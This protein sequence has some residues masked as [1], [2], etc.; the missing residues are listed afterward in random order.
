MGDLEI[1]ASIERFCEDKD[2][3]F[4]DD[5][6]G[7]SMYGRTCVGIVTDDVFETVI[8]LCD[9]LRDE[10]Y[11]SAKTALGSTV[12]VDNM[13]LSKIAYFPNVSK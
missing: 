3:S 7:R 4:T 9:F 10:G 8:D 5:Y 11:A 13:G 12:N 2:V 1:I 6:S